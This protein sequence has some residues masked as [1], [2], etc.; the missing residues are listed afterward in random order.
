VYVVGKRL[1]VAE[2]SVVE[3][4]VLTE[5]TVVPPSVY[6]QVALDVGDDDALQTENVTV[7]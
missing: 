2:V 5:P 6:V 4:G 1:Y 3:D 7:P